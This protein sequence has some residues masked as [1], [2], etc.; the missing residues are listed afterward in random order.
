[1]QTLLLGNRHSSR[2]M[3][4]VERNEA[5]NTLNEIKDACSMLSQEDRHQIEIKT[6]IQYAVGYSILIRSFLNNVCKHQVACIAQNYRLAVE[7]RCD[8]IVIYEPR[9]SYKES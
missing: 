4:F 2:L 3:I 1:V 6:N 5:L 7:E 8:G 9:T